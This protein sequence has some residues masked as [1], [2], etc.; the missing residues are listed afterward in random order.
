M[1]NEIEKYLNNTIDYNYSSI[2]SNIKEIL[3]N[4]SIPDFRICCDESNNPPIISDSFLN[5][6]IFFNKNIALSGWD[7]LTYTIKK[8]SK[9]NLRVLRKNKLNEIYGYS[10]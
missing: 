9:R 4:N 8:D 5:I 1:K 3:K 7:V 2:K 10:I 6:E